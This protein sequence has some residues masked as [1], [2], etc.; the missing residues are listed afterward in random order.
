MG[1]I[2]TMWKMQGQKTPKSTTFKLNSKIE[3]AGL[4]KTPLNIYQIDITSQ[5]IRVVIAITFA[6][7][8]LTLK[9]HIIKSFSTSHN[10]FVF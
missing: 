7:S 6:S 2:F 4:S 10:L 8:L 3:V 9:E 1:L 5:K